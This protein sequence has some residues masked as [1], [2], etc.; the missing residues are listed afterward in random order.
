MPGGRT[1]SAREVRETIDY[2]KVT[3]V[4]L[5]IDILNSGT[6]GS[7]VKKVASAPCPGREDG[8]LGAT[9]EG[10][11]KG[12]SDVARLQQGERVCAW[13]Q[14]RENVGQ[15]SCILVHYR[16]EEIESLIWLARCTYPTKSEKGCLDCS[17]RCWSPRFCMPKEHDHSRR[18]QTVHELPMLAMP[19]VL[20]HVSLIR[21]ASA[22]STP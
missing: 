8:Q 5:G 7:P 14:A 16:K 9:S 21:R 19:M 15:G 2:W 10:G 12:R 20:L 22:A 1:P 11:G 17:D 4:C 18:S 6:P 3:K 13:W